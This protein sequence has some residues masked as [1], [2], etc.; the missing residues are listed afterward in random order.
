MD[1]LLRGC[2]RD[3]KNKSFKL[4]PPTSLPPWMLFTN[5][6]VTPSQ[7]HHYQDLGS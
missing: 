2:A 1:D 3:G 4:K 7:V 5:G 6:T